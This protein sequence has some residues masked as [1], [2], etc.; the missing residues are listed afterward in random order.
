MLGDEDREGDKA[1]AMPLSREGA[2]REGRGHS[3][4]VAG[5]QAWM[6]VQRQLGP[7]MKRREGGGCRSERGRGAGEGGFQREEN[8][9]NGFLEPRKRTEP[10]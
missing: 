4:V 7:Q 5:G 6:C 1:R 2:P 8:V 3:S 10:W 9:W